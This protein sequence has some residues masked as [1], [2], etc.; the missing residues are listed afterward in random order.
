V[1]ID[2]GATE[3][4]DIGRKDPGSSVEGSLEIKYLAQWRQMANFFSGTRACSS[5]D[6]VII[7]VPHKIR[8]VWSHLKN[9]LCYGKVTYN[10]RQPGIT[11]APFTMPFCECFSDLGT[12]V[13]IVP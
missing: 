3:H 10:G 6:I 1:L 9:H 11:K 12:V 13:H 5:S 4:Y 7:V 2:E 8:E